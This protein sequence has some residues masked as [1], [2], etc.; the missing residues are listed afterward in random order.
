MIC[1][2]ERRRGEKYQAGVKWD[3]VMR[4]KASVKARSQNW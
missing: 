1:I 3:P 4:P 2:S